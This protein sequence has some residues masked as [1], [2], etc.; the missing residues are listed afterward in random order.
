MFAALLLD[1]IAFGIHPDRAMASDTKGNAQ[2]ILL[3]SRI[4]ASRQVAGHSGL[5]AEL[6]AQGVGVP[7]PVARLVH[8]VLELLEHQLLE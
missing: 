6:F 1:D 5:T 8:L 4:H 2:L 7:A 3:V